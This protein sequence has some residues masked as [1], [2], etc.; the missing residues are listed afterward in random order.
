MKRQKKTNRRA[1][2]GYALLVTAI[3]VAS[4]AAVQMRNASCEN[5][6]GALQ[7]FTV[8]ADPARRAHHL[9]LWL[10]DDA[11]QELVHAQV[12]ALAGAWGAQI[13]ETLLGGQVGLE[14]AN[15]D[16]GPLR[17]EN[18]GEGVWIGV[19][20]S[21]FFRVPTPLPGVRATFSASVTLRLEMLLRAGSQAGTT[22]AYLRATPESLS[23]FRAQLPGGISWN[24][25][26]LEQ[27]LRSVLA[28]RVIDR[29]LFV[30][31]PLRVGDGRLAVLPV[32][33]AHSGDWLEI[34]LG[35]PLDLP[36]TLPPRP[37]QL[38]EGT[39]NVAVTMQQ[40]LI[41][42]VINAWLSP[43]QDQ[44]NAPPIRFASDGT[45]DPSG[46]YRIVMQN[47]EVTTPN[48]FTV[49]YYGVRTD[50]PCGW[51]LVE[52]ELIVGARE[53]L[54]VRESTVIDTS[55]ARFLV[56]SRLPS[57]AEMSEVVRRLV[58][59]VGSLSAFRLPSGAQVDFRVEQ[60]QGMPTSDRPSGVVAAGTLRCSECAQ[61]GGVR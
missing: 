43:S 49:R 1:F 13:S 7:G 61:R 45:A 2:A 44:A 40:D 20:P 23:N 56:E 36:E 38:V 16:L 35:L 39:T 17:L 26:V 4:C 14:L 6:D 25:S 46:S 24:L 30:L 29:P 55:A 28:E 31:H 47:L 27:V 58:E 9:S 12:Y 50:W 57:P 21:I 5:V 59:E 33:L 8:S 53:S 54:E 52:T 60:I 19:S 37:E 10:S 22:E 32:G 51:A 48:T 34:A 11:I 3:L 41:P 15:V 18:S 42:W